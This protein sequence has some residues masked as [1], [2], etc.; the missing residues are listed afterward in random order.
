MLFSDSDKKKINLN[1][2]KICVQDY[3]AI[4]SSL[5]PIYMNAEDKKDNQNKNPNNYI[6]TKKILKIWKMMIIIYMMIYYV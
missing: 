4:T 3:Y 1:I 5:P 6:Y 2:Y